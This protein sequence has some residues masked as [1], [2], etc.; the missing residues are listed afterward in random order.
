MPV[1]NIQGKEVTVGEEFLSLSPEEQNDTV[2]EI[3]SSMNLTPEAPS[4]PQALD[5]KAGETSSSEGQAY[6]AGGVP[7]GGNANVVDPDE[8]KNSGRQ[9]S[10][11][12]PSVGMW[13]GMPFDEAKAKFEEYANQ[14][15]SAVDP[16]SSQVLYNGDRVPLP[17][18]MRD[19]T[20]GVTGGQFA[21]D[22]ARS[23]G[24][25]AIALP[26]MAKDLITG[27][28]DAREI[29]ELFPT[30]PS[31]E[32]L[33]GTG[34]E[35][36]REGAGFAIGGAGGVAAANKVGSMIPKVGEALTKIAPRIAGLANTAVK[37]VAGA[38]GG[39]AIVDPDVEGAIVGNEAYFDSFD[40]LGTDGKGTYSEELLNK[41]LN[42]AVDAVAT[43]L[44]AG[45]VV[46]SA[47]EAAGLA[48]RFIFSGIIN[49][50][51]EDYVPNQIIKDV[52]DTAATIPENASPE[53]IK[54]EYNRII[55]LVQN[56]SG[57]IVKINDDTIRDVATKYD[58]LSAAE[59]GLRAS[60]T[61][62]DLIAA[63]RVRAARD[64]LSD[65]PGIKALEQDRK[66]RGTQL[67]DD[68]YNRGGGAE[69]VDKS[70]DLLV[71]G[72]RREVKEF[73]DEATD[74]RSQAD[75]INNSVDD[76]IR[77]D[78]RFAE[79]I[80]RLENKTN[81]N[82]RDREN[83]GSQAIVDGIVQAERQMDSQMNDA[84]RAVERV[85][86]SG[87]KYDGESLDAARSRVEDLLDP[88]TLAAMQDET[89]NSF[90]FLYNNVLDSVK[91][92]Q[93][94]FDF[95][96]DQWRRLQEF[97]QHIEGDQ[98]ESLI[99]RSPNAGPRLAQARDDALNS[100]RNYYDIFDDG[101]VAKIAA[102]S[103]KVNT[104]GNGQVNTSRQEA[105]TDRANQT[106]S[107][108]LGN[109][110]R[111]GVREIRRTLAQN[112]QESALTDYIISR[113]LKNLRNKMTGEGKTLTDVDASDIVKGFEEYGANLADTA[114]EELSRIQDVI[115]QI[116]DN[117]NVVRY[118]N[119]EADEV[120][121]RGE[122]AEKK[123]FGT[124]G[125][126]NKFLDQQG[127]SRVSN[128]E[129][130][131]DIF[132]SKNS[133]EVTPKLLGRTD[134]E[135]LPGV[136][137]A[138][139]KQFDWSDPKK[140]L[141]DKDRLLQQSEEVFKDM[142]EVTAAN[143][144]LIDELGD[145]ATTKKLTTKSIT[146]Q[147]GKDFITATG[148]LISIV[149]G[150]LNPKA[151][152]ARV[153]ASIVRD[154]TDKSS[155][156]ADLMNKINSNPEEFTRIAREFVEKGGNITTPAQKR[157]YYDFFIK[158]GLIQN[159]SEED[160]DMYLMER[161]SRNTVEDDTEKALN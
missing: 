156:A 140:I 62:E 38:I 28:D 142:P 3:A 63:E 104:F 55:N 41:K 53:V 29:R 37:G 127:E 19:G 7:V 54:Q 136:Q 2:E 141:K 33:A 137:A 76:L 48:N 100:A 27:S 106:V 6:D 103:K 59:K 67:Q 1:L 92:T 84:Y 83:Q 71:A 119:E 5:P 155:V 115:R 88:Q 157:A 75:I 65:L 36:I 135:T 126:L 9:G 145:T 121:K 57:D 73:A 112:G 125:P 52:L 93:S 31:D 45:G 24:R 60:G 96:T 85:V 79:D 86:P 158:G 151:L 26:A 51:S 123:L 40:A 89:N 120:V 11:P 23:V 97:R 116:S 14:E 17:E 42:V 114:P 107:S 49:R 94:R 77:N 160:T 50:F 129:S 148:R 117:R 46:K 74:L 16:L 90:R 138:F 130:F 64:A 21:I 149:L 98:L 99:A 110:S 22:V 25:E 101:P 131:D 56:N 143:R 68:L 105:F 20:A 159:D 82:F 95:G 150:Q 109:E 69:G 47:A 72:G 118:L 128:Q 132:G 113:G 32:G 44:I 10:L 18:M 4:E 58:T 39:A 87:A 133:R 108:T 102:D 144:L 154:M 78:P 81:I 111:G 8:G 70:G 12:R 139:S 146:E 34:Q 152:K 13:D 134:S 61:P 30:I 15:G 147:S 43:G 124:G 35:L 122:E 91:R 153:G 66:V 161:G 80:V